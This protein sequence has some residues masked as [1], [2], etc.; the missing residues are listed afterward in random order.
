MTYT[1]IPYVILGNT[2]WAVEREDGTIYKYCSTK[3]EAEECIGE[4]RAS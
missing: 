2:L 1:A 4:L 3:E